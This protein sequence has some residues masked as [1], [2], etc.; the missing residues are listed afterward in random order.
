MKTGTGYTGHADSP[1]LGHHNGRAIFL[2]YNGI[3][4]DKSDTGGNVL[5][6]HTLAYLETLLP[7]FDGERVIYGARTRFDKRRLTD[8]RITFHQL[9]YALAVKTWF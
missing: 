3:L 6:H 4:K 2:L 5:N 7:D 8:R 9:P 1:L